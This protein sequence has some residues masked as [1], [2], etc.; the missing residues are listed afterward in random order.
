MP[1]VSVK[2]IEN[3]FTEEQKMTLVKELTVAFF[4]ESL[5]KRPA[6]QAGPI[7]TALLKKSSKGNGG[8]P[9]ICY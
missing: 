5:W 9:D 2:V 7:F 1:I 6:L 3:C 4:V 8:L